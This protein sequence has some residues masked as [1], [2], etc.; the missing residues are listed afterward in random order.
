MNR[1]LSVLLLL[2]LLLPLTALAEGEEAALYS[3][4]IDVPGAGPLQYYAQNDPE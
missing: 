4:V 2:L 1:Q 3:R